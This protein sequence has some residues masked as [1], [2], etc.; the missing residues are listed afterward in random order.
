[1][2]VAWAGVPKSRGTVAQSMCFPLHSEGDLCHLHKI[3]REPNVCIYVSTQSAHTHI[4]ACIFR[5]EPSQSSHWFWTKSK[6][7]SS[8]FSSFSA[9]Q[10]S[11][12][13][14][15]AA[16]MFVTVLSRAFFS[17]C[18]SW[19]P[20][21]LRD[22]TLVVSTIHTC[23]TNFSFVGSDGISQRI[24]R[25]SDRRNKPPTEEGDWLLLLQW[26]VGK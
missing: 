21:L 20:A 11:F 12:S 6:F 7:T 1:M 17:C 22:V 24:T 18:L 25:T 9:L 15:H 13:S 23:Q 2:T 19:S 26:G 8:F 10:T 14:L 4:Y 5:T 3:K 16:T